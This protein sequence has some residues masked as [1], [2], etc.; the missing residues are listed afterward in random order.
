MEAQER[1]HFGQKTQRNSYGAHENALRTCE[2]GK[3]TLRLQLE[4]RFREK[5]IRG[6]KKAHGKFFFF[7]FFSSLEEGS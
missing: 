1:V 2:D 3:K 5:R 4:C 6:V 7:F